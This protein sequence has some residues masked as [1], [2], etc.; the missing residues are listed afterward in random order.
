MEGMDYA[1]RQIEKIGTEAF[2]K[3]L[4]TRG[5]TGI[6]VSL[7]PKELDDAS[8]KIKE[9]CLDTV[10]SMMSLTSG[11]SGSRGSL[12]D[13]CSRAAVCRAASRH[14]RI[15]QTRSKRSWA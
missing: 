6:G 10:L 13:T 3:E 11:R 4:Q 1:L 8:Q 12:T 14:G 15:T 2:R 7:S 5:R 9:M